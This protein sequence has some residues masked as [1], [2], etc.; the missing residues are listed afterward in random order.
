MYDPYPF[1]ERVLEALMAGENV[2]LVTPT[3]SGKTRATSLPFFQ[4]RAFDDGL[5]PE[6]MR[7]VVP[8]RVLASQFYTTCK[9][10]YENELDLE[11]F[12]EI[13]TRY[14]G[15]QQD[16]LSIQTGETPQDPQFEAMVT[17]CTIDQLLASGLGVPY[18][19]GFKKANINVGAVC[20]SYLILDEPHLYPLSNDGRSYK[21]AFTTCL[22]L[23]RLTKGL[24]RFVFMSATMSQELVERL[25]T[26]LDARLI[27]VDDDELELLNKGRHRIF[28][29][30]E[31]PMSAQHILQQH[32]RCSL[33]VCNTVQHAQETYLQL[34]QTIERQG[35][36][37]E[38]RLLHSRFTDEDRKRQGEELN[39]LLGKDQWRDGV[40][41]RQESVIVVATQVV[42][43][44][45][46]ISVQVLHSENAPVNSL[47]QRAGRCA[48]FE[49]QQGRV[50]VYPLVPGEEGKPA[51][52]LPYA[53]AQCD[54]TWQAL[55]QFSGH[56]VGF[57]EEQQLVNI[58]HTADDLVLLERYEEHRGEIQEAITHSLRTSE[59]TN[60]ELI[61]DV[62]QVQVVIHNDPDSELKDKP[63]RWQSFGLYPE[64]LMGKHWQR[65]QERQSELDL[66]WI[67][68]RAELKKGEQ[69]QKQSEGDEE[70]DRLSMSYAWSAIANESEIRGSL[71]LA[72]PN[73]LATYD[74]DL[75]F[76]FLDGRLELPESWKQRLIA[77]DY[78]SSC[79]TNQQDQ[80]DDIPTSLQRYEQH[81]GGL[82]DAYHYAIRHE[83]AYVT[84]RLEQAM[85]LE[86][87]T[88]NH[89]IQLAIATHDLGKLDDHWQRWARA[90][91]RLLYEK[92]QW[93]APYR[94]PDKAAFLAKTDYDYRSKEQ[95]EW[96]NELQIKRPRHAC[97]SVMAGRKLIMRSL[98]VSSAD[99]RNLPVVRAICYAIARHHTP[100]AHEYGITKID[101]TA[102]AAIQRALENVR[103]GGSWNYDLDHLAFQFEKGDLLPVNSNGGTWMTEP[104]V[105]SGPEK[106]LETWLAFLIV[107]A[108]RLADQRADLYAILM[109]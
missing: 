70:D 109:R 85:G 11:R 74:K 15:F 78:Q 6:T 26:L 67:C 14:R 38:L 27:T 8:M 88:I 94:A 47:V 75:G 45:L 18:S 54:A 90:W 41:Q 82:A 32:D 16:I 100:T 83:M 28:E 35:R 4:N 106:L 46:D 66:A 86:T 48:R 79:R 20:G 24:T 23:L 87:G 107:R 89:A 5:L 99:K 19:L 102:Q 50:I 96:Q 65:L 2:V 56:V 55:E 39:Q 33:V 1:Q 51:S 42:E 103:R 97:E 62:A 17:A 104:N 77:Q 21:G 64:A 69:P 93:T 92:G 108:L 72:I 73:Q 9:D 34:A 53:A 10:L 29:R 71:I 36:P 105:M 101:L 30:A 12:R 91:Q 58:V 84:K 3:G 40:Y 43:V 76:V 49:R 25:C 44:G 59:R 13:A 22:E 68:K 31:Q 98:K 95:R 63:W 37:I 80:R 7:Y 61:R 52:T 57:R 81:I 60:S